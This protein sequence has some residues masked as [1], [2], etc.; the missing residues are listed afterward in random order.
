MFIYK[1]LGCLVM[2]HPQMLKHKHDFF[3]DALG[4]S[5]VMV[6]YM[7]SNAHFRWIW[8]TT[9]F[10]HTDGTNYWNKLIKLS[11]KRLLK[12]AS[13]HHRHSRNHQQ[14]LQQP[15]FIHV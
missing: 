2:T 7:L 1:F 9:D 13:F 12:L 4:L 14:R 11:S 5:A 3:F 6:G 8:D 15:W 10:S